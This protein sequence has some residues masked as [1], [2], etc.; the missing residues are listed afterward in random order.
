MT[1]RTIPHA[2]VLE[3][4][5]TLPAYLASDHGAAHPTTGRYSCA[6]C[7]VGDSGL[8]ASEDASEVGWDSLGSGAVRVE[9]SRRGVSE[10]F[11]GTLS[12]DGMVVIA[13]SEP[14][15]AAGGV[16]SVSLVAE[17]ISGSSPHA[18]VL[19]DAGS[20]ASES[21]AMTGQRFVRYRRGGGITESRMEQVAPTRGCAK[22]LLSTVRQR[23][24]FPIHVT[25]SVRDGE[26]RRPISYQ[27]AISRLADLV[28]EH[29]GSRG[30][31]LLYACG[32]VDYF[33][34]FAVQEVLRL[35]GVRNLTGNA[36]HCLNAGA[37]HNETLTGQEGP[38]TTIDQ[39]LRG[40]GERLYLLNGWNGYVTHPPAFQ[41]LLRREDL[42]AY[43]VEVQVT[44]SAKAI[45]E[46]LGSDRVLLIRPRT[47]PMLAMAVIR[48]ILVEHGDAIDHRFVDR[49][50]DRESFE[51]LR[52]RATAPEFAAD[53]VASR[54]AA[55]PEYVD[56]LATAI[57]RIAR[58]IARAGVAPVNIPSVGL[59]Q[60]SGIVAHCLWGC[61]MAL[62][63]KYG[64][65]SDGS[66]AGGTLRLPGQIN[67]QSEVQGL[68]RNVFMGRIRMDGHV[69][70]AR[71]MGLNDDAY[72]RVLEDEPR[73]ALDYAEPADVPE[74]FLFFGT[75]FE[76]NMMQ[77]RR[78]LDKL[79][80]PG[81]RFVVV[82]PI[83]DPFAEQHAELIIPSPPHPATTKLYQ[84]G[85]WRLS[86]G[87]PH[88]RAAPETRSDATILY[89]LMAEITNR[90]ERDHAVAEAHPV[91]AR[92]AAS[93]WLRGRFCDPGL[94]RVDGEVSRAHLWDRIQAYMGGGSGPLYCRPEHADG[95]PIAWH[96]L[97]AGSVIYGGVGT[98]RFR[99]D[100]DREDAQ[101]F[102]DVYRRPT[103]FKF[104]TP[105]EEDLHFP[106]GVILNSG[107]SSLSDDRAAVQFAT[108][109]FNS[110][111]ATP[112]AGMP[113]DAPLFVSHALAK[114]HGLR[115]GDQARVIGRETGEAIVVPV[116]VSDRVKG[117]T[118]YMS[119][120]KSRAQLESGVYVNDVTE[121]SGR[122]RYS[123]QTTVKATEVVLE[124][125]APLRLDPSTLD[126]T[127]ELPL[128]TGQQTPLHVTDVL[129]ETHDVMTFRFQGDPMCRFVFQPGQFLSLVLD[130]D[131]KKVVRS[132]SISST[133]TRPYVLEITVKR[134][135][136]GLVSNWL[137]DNLKPGDRI[138]ASGPRG[139]F[140]L[141][142][143]QIPRK[144]LFLGA[145]SGVTP[146]MSMARWLCD[147]S[148]DVDV[149]FLNSVL[150]SR[151]VIFVSEMELLSSRYRMFSPVVMTT[152]REY[153]GTTM[154]GRISRAMIDA[155][156]P[157]LH[158]RQVYMCGPPGFMDAA[159]AILTDME[160]DLKN[161][162][163]ES[164]GGVRTSVAD[165]PAPIG[166]HAQDVEDEVAVGSFGV[167][168]VRSGKTQ[169]ADGRATLLDIAEASDVDI[170]Y[171][172]RVGSC[173]ACRT[174]L[175]DGEV[176][177]E[178]DGGLTPDER[179]QGYVLT[180]VAR[181][182]TD[183]TLDA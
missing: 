61:A 111:K 5:D 114:T 64:L 21:G 169:R 168:F 104:F 155:M 102:G 60:T 105:T 23:P 163:A 37:V 170:D 19:R 8:V 112:L 68:S 175:V 80:Q 27:E 36:E 77:R 116:V 44:E 143:G 14:L 74:L 183:C 79:T 50:A 76:A 12:D 129:R 15:V 69:D 30:R 123:S 63:G 177:C 2:G 165:K 31:T 135:P 72:E 6:F 157:D 140:C 33:T 100:Y 154:T 119:F 147:V 151:D 97:L 18:I 122:C 144:L 53:L 131:G 57:R 54:I 87:V 101:P 158:E 160:F 83:P 17:T 82:D 13:T 103:R 10:V 121:S 4:L 40:D 11:E 20:V 108:N 138:E 24:A 16:L 176:T 75:Q 152:T 106:E 132:Y 142:P 92:H 148:A 41:E 141:R 56:R 81:V 161:L 3:D 162:H 84:N 133:P 130:I 22:L 127:E 95:K 26:G 136:G 99:L 145:G 34:I 178:D 117:D 174:R 78:W 109:T 113:D 166:S 25:P 71:R 118:T 88:K 115:T 126:P 164:F 91:L 45:A 9:L 167:S 181:P 120:H 98:T 153:S 90:V 73:A 59:S 125:V 156:A 39:A 42:D 1:V 67:A 29:L 173:G 46:R 172:C 179:A 182:R 159:R 171:A 93:G 32:Q 58:T 48:E 55:G 38:F 62:V 43:L 7:G 110:G 94:P 28:L 180:C 51:N 35:L 124:R 47:D 86:L 107:R 70:A 137:I 150:T 134:V 66:L 85:E 149:V 128:W 52:A 139:N 146:L 49:F 96:E 65:R 89:D